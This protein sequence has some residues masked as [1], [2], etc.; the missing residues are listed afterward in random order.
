M[1]KKDSLINQ[2]IKYFNS[3]ELG[4]IVKRQDYIR[5]VGIQS[6]DWHKNISK[7][8][9]KY[10]LITS[11]YIKVVGRGQFKVI[12][13]IPDNITVKELEEES[14]KNCKNYYDNI[15]KEYIKYFNSKKGEVIKIRH[16]LED[17]NVR[18]LPRE[19][20]LLILRLL[21]DSGF[22]KENKEQT[23]LLEQEIPQELTKK[24]LNILV[25]DKDSLNSL[26][27]DLKYKQI[28]S[29]GKKDDTGRNSEKT[30][31]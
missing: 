20:K 1:N 28:L 3:F 31:R 14:R 8:N 29:K 17:K 21:I 12:K 30:S 24:E 4:K 18:Y 13:K 26:F 10:L 2:V 25:Y 5:S 15:F 7:D 6:G 16:F 11:G 23:F 9:Y 19:E 22:L 27:V